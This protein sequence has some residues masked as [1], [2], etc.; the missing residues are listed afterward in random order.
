MTQNIGAPPRLST[1]NLGKFTS[2]L[3]L[4]TQEYKVPKTI[5]GS[6][7]I[8][9]GK[10]D[11]HLSGSQKQQQ[12]QQHHQH[13][14]ETPQISSSPLLAGPTQRRLSVSAS[15]GGETGLM[16]CVLPDDL[17][18]QILAERIQLSDCFRG[19]VIDGL[20]TL[21]ARNAPSALL[22]LLK[23]IGSR[24]HIYVINMSQDYVAMKA[25][26]K[27]KKEQ[28]ENKRKEALAKEKERLRTL[29]EE[30]YD[31]LT[32]EEKVAFDREVRQAL[33]E[34]GTRDLGDKGDRT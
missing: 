17:L 31:A 8:P 18:I 2:E 21:F 29:D 11:S 16:S 3:T 15:I 1:E 13:Q 5:R 33:R 27:A 30:E 26:E 4:M 25:Q 22:C 19:V 28:E 34:E 14:S 32:A 12:Q 10:A 23:A 7:M 9:K 6:V 24:E 20:D